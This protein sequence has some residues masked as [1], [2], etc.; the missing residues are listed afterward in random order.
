MSVI[1]GFSNDVLFLGGGVKARLPTYHLP[2]IP[3]HTGAVV[4]SVH[5]GI[6]WKSLGY[7][8]KQ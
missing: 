5:R 2:N 3:W 8:R 6:T 7:P 4:T 1:Y